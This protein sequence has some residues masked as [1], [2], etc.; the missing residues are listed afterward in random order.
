MTTVRLARRPHGFPEE[1]ADMKSTMMIALVALLSVF[2]CKRTAP[3]EEAGSVKTTGGT[4]AV[5]PVTVDQVRVVM[6]DQR[7]DAPTIVKAIRITNDNGVVTLTGFV[8]DK[9][10]ETDLVNR[11]KSMQGVKDVHDELTVSPPKKK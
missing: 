3:S 1:V 9:K 10:M 6:L 8:A 4:V 7:P 5:V 11:V 2:G